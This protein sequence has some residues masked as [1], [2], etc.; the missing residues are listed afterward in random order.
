VTTLSIQIAGSYEEQVYQRI[1][2]AIPKGLAYPTTNVNPRPISERTAFTIRGTLGR[3]VSVYLNGSKITESGIDSTSVRL[4]LG[5]LDP[6]PVTHW[7]RL[8]DSAGEEA[9]IGI[10]LSYMALVHAGAALDY[11]RHTYLDYLVQYWSL[12]SRW[13]SRPTEFRF[14]YHHSLPDTQALRSLAVKLL[15]RAVFHNSPTTG[16]IDSIVAAF[17]LG[18]PVAVPLVPDAGIDPV[19]YPL[20]PT[21]AAYAGYDF[22]VWLPD[23]P[24]AR[25]LAL[26]KL[27]TNIPGQIRLRSAVEGT[28]YLGIAMGSWGYLNSWSPDQELSLPETG[29]QTTIRSSEQQRGLQHLMTLI[30]PMD[31]WLAFVTPN[32]EVEVARRFWAYRHDS[33]IE[34]PGLGTGSHY[35]TSTGTFDSRRLDSG[36]PFTELWTG[37]S[38]T[39]FDVDVPDD[40]VIAV[41]VELG[42]VR[43]EPPVAFAYEYSWLSGSCST[44]KA[45]TNPLH[46][47]APAGEI[48]A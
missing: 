45:V 46:G 21:P 39:S 16:G 9:S 30:G 37:V 23:L 5:P 12:T 31:T 41:S 8:V 10:T 3:T 29:W 43:R 15:G 32:S 7:V 34:S 38:L 36:E 24:T 4:E 19:I 35:D 27:A 18:Y 33:V 14:Q 13:S 1:V 11:F 44:T 40:S 20:L 22:N 6:W 47:G 2:T 26:W 25:E 17:T 28:S 48:P 42:N